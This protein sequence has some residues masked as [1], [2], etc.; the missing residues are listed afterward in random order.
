[1][2]ATMFTK[3]EL[4]EACQKAGISKK[5]AGGYFGGL[6][7]SMNLMGSFIGPIVSPCICMLVGFDYTCI[8]MGTVLILFALFFM[9]T[10]K[11]EPK[12]NIKEMSNIEVFQAKLL[13]NDTNL[14]S[15]L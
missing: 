1:M 12:N 2:F 11:I 4:M 8:T 6:K 3:A 9:Y 14:N 13:Q 5:E 10:V 7:G 15:N